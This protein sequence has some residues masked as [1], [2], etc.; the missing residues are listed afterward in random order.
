MIFLSPSI[1]IPRQYLKSD[2]YRVPPA[3]FPIQSSPV[4][5]QFDVIGYE[6]PH[7]FQISSPF[8]EVECAQ[9]PVSKFYMRKQI[10]VVIN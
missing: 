6:L 5:P 1:R 8:V 2:L 9:E 7:L 10:S 4:K 3:A